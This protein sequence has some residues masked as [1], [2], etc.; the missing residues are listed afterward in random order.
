MAFV[1]EASLKKFA[2]MVLI[3]VFKLELGKRSTALPVFVPVS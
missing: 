1:P 3:L 2:P